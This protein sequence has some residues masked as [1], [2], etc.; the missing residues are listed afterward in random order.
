VI[1]FLDDGACGPPLE[2]DPLDTDIVLGEGVRGG[3]EEEYDR[4]RVEVP[5]LWLWG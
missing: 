4:Q 2:P 1:E 3:E 5:A